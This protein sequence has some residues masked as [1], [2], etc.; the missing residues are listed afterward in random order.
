MS[1]SAGPSS[2][3]LVLMQDGSR[4]SI[5]SSQHKSLTVPEQHWLQEGRKGGKEKRGRK[6]RRIYN[7]LIWEVVDYCSSPRGPGSLPC[8]AAAAFSA[9]SSLA[10]FASSSAAILASCTSFSAFHSFLLFRRRS[11]MG[12]IS[13]WKRLNS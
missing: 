1:T 5:S 2:G 10:F 8:L 13:T 6:K 7:I 9:C 11:S 4:C 12:V 3:G